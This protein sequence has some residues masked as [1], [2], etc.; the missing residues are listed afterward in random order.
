MRDSPSKCTLFFPWLKHL[1][2]T[3]VCFP[4]VQL[5][6]SKKEYLCAPLLLSLSVKSKY[7]G[8]QFV[9][10][11]LAS[12]VPQSWVKGEKEEDEEEEEELKKRIQSKRTTKNTPKWNPYKVSQ[13]QRPPLIPLSPIMILHLPWLEA[14]LLI[15]CC[16]VLRGKFVAV[17]SQ[18]SYLIYLSPKLL[19]KVGHH[20]PH[21]TAGK[22]HKYNVRNRVSEIAQ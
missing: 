6:A 7:L 16:P 4:I 11:T 10:T 20:I 9:V 2:K 17:Q 8:P 15:F 18:I 21:E 22:I 13:T 1:S 3:F 5:A 19:V 12:L 14:L